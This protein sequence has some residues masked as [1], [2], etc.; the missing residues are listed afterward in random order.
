MSGA[1]RGEKLG[2]ILGWGGSFL[3]V[4]ILAV[5]YLTKGAPPP[6]LLGF[7]LVATAAVFI[8]VFAPWR[9]PTRPYWMLLA[10][11]Y[12]LFFLSIAWASWI[13]GGPAELGFTVWSVFLLLPFLLP[14]YLAGKRR[15][16]DGEPHAS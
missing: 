11:I 14:F 2:W 7:A 6:S 13:A 4:L 3:W 10:P 8:Y 15:W 9:H 16:I 5:V 12:S 1:R